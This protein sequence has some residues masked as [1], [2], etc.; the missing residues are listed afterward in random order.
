M[1][2]I[3]YLMF[4]VLLTISCSK[5][6]E[7]DP[8]FGDPTQ[9]IADTL[10]Y[11]KNTLVA[12]PNGWKAFTTTSISKGGYGFYM[13]FSENDR[14]KMVADLDETSASEIKE[15]TYRIRQ[16]MY[17]TLSFDTYN[18]ITKLQDPDPS[19]Y[20]GAPGKGLGSD[21]EYDYVKTHGDTLFF[22]GRKFV[23]PL[24]LVKA[25]AAEEN[26][27]LTKKLLTS[28]ED[29]NTYFEE[30]INV[31]SLNKANCEFTLN[32][33]A[34]QINLMAMIDG[35]VESVQIPYFYSLN[36]NL[37]L[38]GDVSFDGEKFTNV[39]E[40]NGVYK[41]H[42]VS[43]KSFTINKSEE[44]LLPP[45]YKLGTA[46][47]DMYQPGV[48][49]YSSYLPLKTWSTSYSVDWNEYVRLSKTGGYNLTVGESFYNFNDAKKVITMDGYIYQDNTR[50]IG[51]Y[52]MNYSIDLENGT[53]RFLSVKNTTNNGGIMVPYMNQTFFKKMINHD[54]KLSFI[55]D[56]NFG[57]GI[58]FTSVED[59]NYYFSFVY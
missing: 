51:G 29:V 35:K 19:V 33:A 32:I 37:I 1:K 9:R 15:S 44:Y 23:Q 14:L 18:Y 49:N 56:E 12:A 11:V 59:P 36:K 50:F 25:T 4:L 31:V 17:A 53:I 38:L 39:T 2:N 7:V 6:K 24:I 26:A 48:Y 5:P 45:Q 54:F 13:Q 52:V 46:I 28:I 57:P 34:K 47:T 27:F 8:I 55:K 41:L 21:N 42:S 40:E 30:G 58:Q 22:Q 3:F 43:G 10:A 16:I 20:G